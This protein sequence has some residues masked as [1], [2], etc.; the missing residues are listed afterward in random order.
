MRG[1]RTKKKTGEQND[2]VHEHHRNILRVGAVV[3]TFDSDEFGFQLTVCHPTVDT[4]NRWNRGLQPA[5]SKTQLVGSH[6]SVCRTSAGTKAKTA[7]A[8]ASCKRASKLKD[9]SF[10][11]TFQTFFALVRKM[12]GNI[13]CAK[14]YQKH[15]LEKQKTDELHE[16]KN[17]AHHDQYRQTDRHFSNESGSPSLNMKNY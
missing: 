13:Q 1:Q 9:S 8:R 17:V 10:W 5:V 4:W 6:F 11:L 7:N 14:K 2:D 12:I 15:L 16:T 3:N